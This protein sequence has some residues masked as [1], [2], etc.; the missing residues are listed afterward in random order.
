MSMIGQRY[1]IAFDGN[2]A[3]PF[4]IH[5]VKNLI[6]KVSFIAYAGKLNEAVGKC[7]FAVVNMSDDAK[8]SNVFHNSLSADTISIGSCRLF[9][10]TSR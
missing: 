9:G 7:G 2:A 6:L 1:G 8:V 4:N 3:F 5:I 10:V